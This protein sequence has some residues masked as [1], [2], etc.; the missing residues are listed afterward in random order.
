MKSLRNI[1]FS[2]VCVGLAL[3]TMAGCDNNEPAYPTLIITKSEYF[4]DDRDGEAR[5]QMLREIRSATS[6]VD[7]A[8]SRLT[9]TELANALVTAKNAGAIVRVVG[10]ADFRD[11]DGFEILVN[12]DIPVTFGNGEM[13][14]LPD[15]TISQLLNSCGLSPDGARVVCPA[16]EPFEPASDGEMVRPG[17]FNFMSHNFVTLE[18]QVVWNFSAPLGVSTVPMAFRINSQLVWESFNR[19]FNQMY[20]EVFAT[21]LDIYNGPVKS[22]GQWNPVYMTEHGEMHMRFGPQERIVKSVIDDIYKARYTVWIMADSIDE[23][24]LIDALEYKINARLNGQPAFDVRILLNDA[25]QG[26]INRGRLEDLGAT[27]V[28]NVD[29]LPS[30]V[31]IDTA[32]DEIRRGHIASHPLFRTGPFRVI[33]AQP[34]DE[35]EVFRSD[36]FADGLMWSMVAY[37]DQEN[38]ILDDMVRAYDGFY[39]AAQ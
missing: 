37:P 20:S 11:D 4:I 18:D 14:Y 10:D 38:P 8:V 31:L 23:E 28:T 24:F 9:D 25:G 21:T 39:G 12:A 19:E 33:F 17:S 15:P 16:A 26:P 3:G 34:N 2:L 6:Q 30:M 22:S 29:Y 35:V 27:F 36:Y 13:R 5:A 7:V 32:S 1:V